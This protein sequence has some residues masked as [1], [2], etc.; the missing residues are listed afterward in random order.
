MKY[1]TLFVIKVLIIF[2]GCHNHGL[3]TKQKEIE[4]SI[5]SWYNKDLILSDTLVILEDGEK[6][7]IPKEEFLQ[8][9]YKILSIL[10]NDCRSC[11]ISQLLFWDAFIMENI[12][13][14]DFQLVL[15]Y[16]G[17][18]EYFSDVLISELGI[19]YPIVLDHSSQ[20][21]SYDI[22]DENIYHTVLLD[23]ENRVILIGNYF[24]NKQ[25]EVLY[26]EEMGR[27]AQR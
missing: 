24:D 25:L 16:C 20:I 2:Y 18:N 15:F 8:K 11:T 23:H 7:T 3:K 14:Y 5:I 19:K 17:P 1:T 21:L 13:I 10:D 26:L 12:D 9:K 27:N 6:R 22:F 4:K